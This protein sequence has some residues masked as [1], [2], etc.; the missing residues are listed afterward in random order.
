MLVPVTTCATH[1]TLNK[2]TRLTQKSMPN[3]ISLSYSTT[4]LFRPTNPCAKKSSLNIRN[5]SSTTDDL[6]MMSS[7]FG[8]QTKTSNWMTLNGPPSL[9]S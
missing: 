2:I 3:T 4:A 1:A 8:V 5:V 9:T 6:L 7:A